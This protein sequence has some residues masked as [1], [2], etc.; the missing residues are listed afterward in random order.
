MPKVNTK[1]EL[2][3]KIQLSEERQR[4]LEKDIRREKE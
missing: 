3:R 2:D 1:R 4:R